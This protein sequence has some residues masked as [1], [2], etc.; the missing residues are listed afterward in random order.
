METVEKNVYE[1]YENI[2]ELYDKELWNDMPYNNQIDNFLS[3]LKGNKVLDIGCAM[4][5]FTKY[6]ANKGFETVGIDFSPKMIEIANK[7]VKNA[8]FYVMNMLN[9]TLDKKYNGIMAIN[10]VIHIKKNKMIKVIEEFNKVLEN[11]GIIFIILQEGDGE[12]YIEEPLKPDIKE[13]VNFYQ[14]DEIMQLFEKCNLEIIKME[15]IRDDAEFELGNNQL[16]FY[17]RKK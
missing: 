2:A 13:F 16:A 3:M 9:I 8:N 1:A 5:S 7:K 11:D 10:S 4:G 17:L 12:K 14:V 15:K 6:V